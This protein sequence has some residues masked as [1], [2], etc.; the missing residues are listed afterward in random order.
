MSALCSCK[1]NLSCKIMTEIEC[2]TSNVNENWRMGEVQEAFH[3]RGL[4]SM[5]I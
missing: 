5:A 1:F 2:F 3:R 4:G